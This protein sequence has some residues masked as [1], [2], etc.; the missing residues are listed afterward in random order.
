[1]SRIDVLRPFVEKNLAALIGSDKVAPDASGEYVFPHGSA[2]ISLRLLDDP[3]PM[4]QFSSVLVSKPRKKARLL[5]ALNS[6]NASELAI[7][8]FKYEDL[9]IAA[10]EVPADTLD[11][12]QFHD[13]C[14]RFAEAAD[15]LDTLLSKKFGGKTARADQDDDEEAVDA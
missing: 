5:E 8:L 10:W 15:R 13:I 7:R 14:M 6:A 2:D 4:L 3:F 12:R 9:I 11:D 1:M